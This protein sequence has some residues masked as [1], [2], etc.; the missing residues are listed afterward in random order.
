MFIKNLLNDCLREGHEADEMTF[1][2]LRVLI[3]IQ[4]SQQ[5]YEWIL[6]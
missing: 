2:I 4:V 6:S 5:L 1:L 3:M